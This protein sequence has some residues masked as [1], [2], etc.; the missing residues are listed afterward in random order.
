[1]NQ[2]EDEISQKTNQLEAEITQSV[3]KTNFLEHNIL[4]LKGETSRQTAT[5]EG[6]E[7]ELKANTRVLGRDSKKFT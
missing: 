7:S 6:K 2:F 4:T 1:M 3:T 5:V